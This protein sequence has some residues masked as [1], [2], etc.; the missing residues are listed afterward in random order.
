[1]MKTINCYL[2]SSS[3]WNLY[4]EENE[5]SLI[6]YCI[7]KEQIICISSIWTTLEIARGI[8]KRVNQKEITSE[9][10]NLLQLFIEADLEKLRKKRR[11]L[12]ENIKEED[13]ERAKKIIQQ[14]NLYASDAL[15]LA[16]ALNKKCEIFIVDDYHFT[17]LEGKVTKNEEITIYSTSKTPEELKKKLQ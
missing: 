12:L 1:M 9:E 11:I 5:S 7:E 8:K 10:G 17:R 2:E 3:I 6:E 13:I 16:T 4:Y 15:H 14:Y